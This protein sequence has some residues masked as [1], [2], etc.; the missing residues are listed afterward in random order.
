MPPTR[1]TSDSPRTTRRRAK[2]RRL[3][4]S[5][6]RGHRR[7]RRRRRGHGRADA[8]P[9]RRRPPPLA[10]DRTRALDR[11][12]GRPDTAPPTEA[13]TGW[14]HG[15]GLRSRCTTTTSARSGSRS[16][17][18][19]QPSAPRPDTRRLPRSSPYARRSA[20]R[21]PANSSAPNTAATL[22]RRRWRPRARR[23]HRP[24]IPPQDHRGRRLRPHLLPREERLDAVGDRR[25]ADCRDHRTSPP[26]SRPRRPHLLETT[27]LYTR[28][29]TNGVRQVDVRGLV[30]TAFTHRDSRAGDPDLHTH[31]AVAN[32]VETLSPVTPDGSAGT[33]G[34]WLAIDGRPLH[35]AVVSAS[36]TYNTAL[37]RHLADALGVRFAVRAD[38]PGQGAARGRPV[39]EIVGVDPRLNNRFSKRRLSVEERRAVLATA[40]QATHGRP[41]TP[42]EAIQLAQQA[43]LETREAK[44]EPDP[45]RSSVLLGAEKPS[46]CSAV[47]SGSR[48]WCDSTAP[49]P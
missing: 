7:P 19:S 36:E 32:K 48:R 24:A 37:E 23:C 45:W 2:P 47:L 21:S 41:P 22:P 18:D 40:F 29:G 35:K 20:P 34:K 16:R 43:T 31:V 9:V 30:A 8:E 26:S 12:I 15:S 28:E 46:R 14:R 42:V 13:T 38:A 49:H 17:S 44:H 25:P 4:R 11:Q 5:R 33:G 10:T 27:A 39:R 1:V 3:G 6:D